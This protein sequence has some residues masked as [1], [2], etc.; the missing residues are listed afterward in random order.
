M[1]WNIAH[2]KL[3]GIKTEFN[4]KNYPVRNILS[5]L[6]VKEYLQKHAQKIQ[7]AVRTFAHHNWNLHGHYFAEKKK[8][9]PK[10]FLYVTEYSQKHAQKVQLTKQQKTL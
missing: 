10:G 1:E 5:F 8:A 7:L 6:Y 3:S 2:R 9:V 4:F